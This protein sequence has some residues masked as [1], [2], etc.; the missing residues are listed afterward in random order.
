MTYRRAKGAQRRPGSGVDIGYLFVSSVDGLNRFWFKCKRTTSSF[1][2][3]NTIFALDKELARWK[4]LYEENVI[5]K[6]EPDIWEYKYKYPIEEI[7]WTKISANKISS[8]RNNRA[9]VGDYQITYSSWRDLWVKKQG[10]HL[11]YNAEELIKINEMTS[12]YTTWSKK[13]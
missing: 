10:E 4:K 11:G 7:D 6:I 8:A 1:I 13:K 2:C 5:T 3:G 9:V 12:G